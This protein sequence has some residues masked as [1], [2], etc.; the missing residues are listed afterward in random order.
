MHQV[1]I[2]LWWSVFHRF[3]PIRVMPI[4]DLQ[5]VVVDGKQDGKSTFRVPNHLELMKKVGSGGLWMCG[6][7]SG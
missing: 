6:L 3:F 4:Y 1:A 2:D 5:D 7:F